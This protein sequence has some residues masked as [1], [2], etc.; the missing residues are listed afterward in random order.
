MELPLDLLGRDVEQSAATTGAAVP[1]AGKGDALFEEFLDLR[2][3][4][5]RLVESV[6]ITGNENTAGTTCGIFTFGLESRLVDGEDLEA[7][8]RVPP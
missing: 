4:H 7:L 2:S 5:A 3:R 8:V 1:V 6:E